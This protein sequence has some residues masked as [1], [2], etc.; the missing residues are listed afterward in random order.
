MSGLSVERVPLRSTE[1]EGTSQEVQGAVA[2]DVSVAPWETLIGDQQ[3]MQ[4]RLVGLILGLILAVEGIWRPDGEGLVLGLC[5]LAMLAYGLWRRTGVLIMFVVPVAAL[6]YLPMVTVRGLTFTMLD[7]LMLLAVVHAVRAIS[8][9]RLRLSRQVWLLLALSG[10]LVA[11]EAGAGA[12][13]GG[14]RAG[15]VGAMHLLQSWA[16]YALLCLLPDEVDARARRWAFAVLLAASAVFMAASLVSPHEVYGRNAS[17]LFN[18]NVFGLV[19]VLLINVGMVPLLATEQPQWVNVMGGA[20]VVLAIQCLVSSSSRTAAV[21]AVVVFGYWLIQSRARLRLLAVVCV[22]V[23]VAMVPSLANRALARSPARVH[24]VGQVGPSASSATARS[25]SASGAGTPGPSATASGT[26]H[27]GTGGA[28][29]TTTGTSGS[30]SSSRPSGT[31]GLTA[32]VGA[33]AHTVGEKMFAQRWTEVVRLGLRD[34]GI[35]FRLDA[36]Q[37]A[38]HM[39]MHSPVFGYGSENLQAVSVPY[40]QRYAKDVTGSLATT[41]NEYGDMLLR[42]GLAGLALLAAVVWLMWRRLGYGGG[43]TGWSA[44]NRANL[45]ALLVAGMAM[46]SF[47][48]PFASCLVWFLFALMISVTRERTAEGAG[49]GASAL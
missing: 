44:A 49:L 39:W 9:G 40:V 35:A 4:A 3:G 47:S 33:I 48:S 11:V 42:D 26:S 14:V 36:L 7:A 1:D 18:P 6:F 23:V 37:V 24:A 13:F 27:S 43:N 34:P 29:G 15:L 31:T 5:A 20:F 38:F 17:F 10:L 46:P 22:A 8:A 21:T 32:P 2:V 28:S 45:V 30:S 12:H 16:A 25:S 41:D 19:I